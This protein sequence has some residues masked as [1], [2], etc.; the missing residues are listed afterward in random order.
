MILPNHYQKLGPICV[1]MALYTYFLLSFDIIYQHDD[2]K[3]M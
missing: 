3:K 1:Q 2:V